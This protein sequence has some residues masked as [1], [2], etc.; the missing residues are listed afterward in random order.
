MGNVI[1]ENTAL[2]SA[3]TTDNQLFCYDE[4]NRLVWAGATGTSPCNGNVSSGSLTSAYYSQ[5]YTYDAQGRLTSG[6]IGSYT[7]GDSSHP[8]AV[9]SIGGGTYTASYDAV[10]DMTCRAPNSSQT[11][12]GTPTG[13]TMT[14][15]AERRLSSWQN[16][17]TSPTV[18]TAYLY[19]GE[20]Q[21]IE[22]WQNTSGTQTTTGYLMGGV[23]ERTN[24]GTITK[25][26]GAK[27]LPTAIRVGTAGSLNYLAT[28]GLGSVSV[29]VD[30]SGNVV[31]SQLFGPYGA[32]RYSNGTM[33]TSK[34]FTGQRA[35][36]TTG[37]DYYGARYYD[38][39]AGQFTSADSV[40]QGLSRYAYVGGNPETVTDPSG[41]LYA[42]VGSNLQSVST[43]ITVA[44]VLVGA[45]YSLQHGYRGLYLQ[46]AK[47]TAKANYKAAKNAEIAENHANGEMGGLSKAELRELASERNASIRAAEDTADGID[48][49]LGWTKF[50]G[51]LLLGVGI[52]VDAGLSG[53]NQWNQDSSGNY[54]TS[55]RWARAITAGAVHAG[56]DAAIGIGTASLIDW[57]VTALVGAV[58]IETGPAD[59]LIM[60]GAFALTTAVLSGGGAALATTVAAPVVNAVSDAL[61]N[62]V[63]SWF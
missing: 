49:Y 47:N 12:S 36:A 42:N 31:A 14:Y 48:A 23:E 32:S 63:G 56:L 55:Q 4:Q 52:A 53:Y 44:Q 18:Q 13:A 43:A 2:G 34:G 41:H 30:G 51:R 29:A 8:H 10:G 57:G 16:T 45:G 20:G 1:S 33:P 6:A 24:S 3:S 61:T 15:D 39:A 28:D 37:L 7:Y 59:P 40:S 62:V 60:A 9:T 54:S 50:A 46:M 38:S 26:L 35:D 25:Y 17:P 5:A 19:D 22:A 11:C 21:R 27:G 58:F